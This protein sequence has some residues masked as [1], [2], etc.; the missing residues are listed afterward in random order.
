MAIFDMNNKRGISAIVA[1][2]LIILITVAAV[3]II[4]AA[5]IPLVSNQ[6]EK[7]SACLDATSQLSIVDKG[8]TCWEEDDPLTI[9]QTFIQIK[10]GAKEFD[11]TGIYLSTETDGVSYSFNTSSANVKSPPLFS[12]P[13]IPFE[14]E[15]QVIKI[16][17]VGSVAHPFSSMP[18]PDRVSIAPIITLGSSEIVCDVASTIEISECGA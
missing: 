13:K 8:F 16:V 12:A 14:N 5:I 11:L 18:I 4:W 9:R 1:T 7:G 10:R 6:L 2:V 15:I 3:T 17:V